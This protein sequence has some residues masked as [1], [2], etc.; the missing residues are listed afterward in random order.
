MRPAIDD[1]DSLGSDTSDIQLQPAPKS[2]TP[3]PPAAPI[4]LSAPIGPYLASLHPSLGPLAPTL[5][6]GGLEDRVGE[7]LALDR[8][9]I[10]QD[11][12]ASLGDGIK[13]LERVRLLRHVAEECARHAAQLRAV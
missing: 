3:A 11:F 2:T 6:S 9:G 1:R 13:P 8:E 12:V 7:L 5:V 10:L 4:D